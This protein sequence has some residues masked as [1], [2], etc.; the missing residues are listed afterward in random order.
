MTDSRTM[1]LHYRLTPEI[2]RAAL[3][4][5]VRKL[6]EHHVQS[7]L[8]LTLG[9][10]SWVAICAIF[11]VL[12][13]SKAP[14]WVAIFAVFLVLDHAVIYWQI[15]RLARDMAGEAD[16]GLDEAGLFR[17]SAEG[18]D[19]YP[20]PQVRE[21]SERSGWLAIIV[22]V[23][24]YKV[25]AVPETAFAGPDERRAFLE[26]LGEGMARAAAGASSA[27][28]DEDTP[29]LFDDAPAFPAGDAAAKPSGPLQDLRQLG[30]ILS[31]RAL[32]PDALTPEVTKLLWLVPLYFLINLSLQIG[33]FG[34]SGTFFWHDLTEVFSPFAA[35]GL[36]AGL[37]ALDA[38]RRRAQGMRLW[39]GFCLILLL[40]PLANFYT[41]W[42]MRQRLV[43]AEGFL[44]LVLRYLPHLWLVAAGAWLAGRMVKKNSPGR[45]IVGLGAVFWL[46]LV[47]WL[48][49]DPPYL[50]FAAVEEDGDEAKRPR[51]ELSEE[52]LYGQP[53]LLEESLQAVRPGRP[54]LAEIFFLGVGGYGWQDVFLRE[55]RSVEQLFDER[56]DTRGHS[57]ILVNNPA[58]LRELPTANL[59]SLRRALRRMG[60]QMNGEEDL[61]FLFLT[62]HGS[63]EPRFSL[64]LWPFEF[65]DLAPDMLRQALDEA[66]I[67]R[68]VVVISSCYSGGFLPALQDEYTL[69][70][71]AAAADRNSFGC[72]D[73]NEFTDFGR[74]YFDEALR[75]TRSFTEAFAIANA[76]ITAREKSEGRTESRPQM[77]GGAGLKAQLETFANQARGGS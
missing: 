21:I 16:L 72:A 31:F 42:V 50:W 33:W 67:R 38:G 69:V 40:L 34:F 47:F 55:T 60:E 43:E 36:A 19:R 29:A 54:G 3:K 76:R 7:W 57:L 70:I 41:G 4:F 61:L 73:G 25:V 27:R 65:T 51:V 30:R 1:R 11:A 14:W 2:C 28:D 62:S 8:P 9:F 20:W 23:S 6:Y 12:W 77:Q 64:S 18:E 44:V 52:I 48:H 53:R 13:D 75:R 45:F 32:P 37:C 63:R 39:L 15:R 46:G 74:A 26:A 24:R 59:E 58:T 35:A 17:R 5:S 10:L 22:G 56:F 68:R 49:L 71:S 66:G